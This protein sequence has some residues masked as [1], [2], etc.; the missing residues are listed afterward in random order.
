MTS[1]ST[2]YSGPPPP[3]SSSNSISNGM[4]GYIS[5]PESNSRR[6]TR[7]DKE[8]P[9]GST[10]L[11][12]ISE[13]LKSAEASTPVQSHGVHSAPGSATVSSFTDA[14]RGPGNP[15]SQ[16][17]VP[18]SAL[19]SS[20]SSTSGIPDS[21]LSKAIPPPPVPPDSMQPPA[22]NPLNSPRQRLTNSRPSISSGVAPLDT[23]YRSSHQSEPAR[24]GYPFSDHHA[25]HAPSTPLPSTAFT[26]EHHGKS[27]EVRNP[28]AKP[29]EHIAYG[30]TVKR[31]LDVFDAALALNEV[32]TVS[33]YGRH[34]R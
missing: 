26:F 10:L 30:E 33:T 13:A 16:P 3:Y 4:P 27:E 24:P 9:V 34:D 28:F 32:C 11:P 1:P 23:S 8:S 22:L 17:A 12:S 15:F 20:F 14:P 31:H 18:A 29:P 6:S 2:S 19:R 5:P 7:D 25:S 21:S